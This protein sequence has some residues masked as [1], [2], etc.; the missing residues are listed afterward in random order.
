MKT[1]TRILAALACA[2]VAASLGAQVSEPPLN[3]VQLA[4]NASVEVAQDSLSI[5]LST[6][7]DGADAAL[8]QSQLKSALDAALSEA[9]KSASPGQMDVR[10]GNFSLQPRSG[11]DG[12]ISGWQGSTELVLEGQD[13]ARISA[14]AGKIQT[15]TLS[16]VQFSLSR[17]Q[18]VKAEQKAQGQAIERFR[19]KAEEIARAFGFSGYTL[20][21]VN[22][23]A[24]DSGFNPRVR[25]LAVDSVSSMGAA[26]VPME[27]G[28]STVVVNVSGS[29]QLH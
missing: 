2:G 6:T 16:G 5:S 25:M 7:R 17:E 28:K 18:R 1:S 13:F 26:P 4:S 15:L 21:E 11:R 29:V 8:L 22:V 3:V 14:T 23:N 24:S 12:R 20:R 19:S 27:A 10:T 9:K